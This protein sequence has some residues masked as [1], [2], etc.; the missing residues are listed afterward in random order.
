MKRYLIFAM[1][2]Y[3]P[4]GGFNDF[5]ISFDTLQECTQWVKEC[6]KRAIEE[7]C[8]RE[9]LI[10]IKTYNTFEFYHIVD[11]LTFNRVINVE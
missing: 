5:V 9:Y 6:K 2:H 4:E 3:Y 7:E 10:D 1:D 11:G 8:P